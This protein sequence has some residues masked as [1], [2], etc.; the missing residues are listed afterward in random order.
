ME[1]LNRITEDLKASGAVFDIRDLDINGNDIMS[2]GV[3]PGPVVGQILSKV[4]N[5]YI[6]EKCRNS[7]A[8]LMDEARRI[9]STKSF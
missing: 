9:I 8:S 1:E 4:F 2:L 7:K 5:N 6:E 3:E